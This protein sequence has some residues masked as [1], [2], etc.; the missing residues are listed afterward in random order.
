MDV[1]LAIT[2]NRF[3]QRSLSASD[4]SIIMF[5]SSGDDVEASSSHGKWNDPLCPSD[6]KQG[7]DSNN[8]LSERFEHHGRICNSESIEPKSLVL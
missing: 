8:F 5:I 2:R 7:E 1:K 6:L 3:T 4:A